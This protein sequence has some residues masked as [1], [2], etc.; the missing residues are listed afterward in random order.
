MVLKRAVF[1]RDEIVVV[2]IDRSIEIETDL[3]T[4]TNKQTQV[5][6]QMGTMELILQHLTAYLYR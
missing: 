4:E 3:K 5:Q 6:T 1:Q 2:V